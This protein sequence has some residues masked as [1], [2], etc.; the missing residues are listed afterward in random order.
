MTPVL[1]G[2][3]DAKS[4][5]HIRGLAFPSPSGSSTVDRRS[6]IKHYRV[7]IGKFAPLVHIR[8]L[9][10]TRCHWEMFPHN[11]KVPEELLKELTGIM[12]HAGIGEL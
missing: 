3:G 8:G 10:A 6:Q 11:R 4:L 5:P 7:T 12:I 2:L 1:E 9:T